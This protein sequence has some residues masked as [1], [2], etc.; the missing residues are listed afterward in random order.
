MKLHKNWLA[1]VGTVCGLAT[2]SVLAEAYVFGANE[3][4]TSNL[5]FGVGSTLSVADGA[6]VTALGPLSLGEN[7]A[8]DITKTDGGTFELAT[9]LPPDAAN[10]DGP[11][12]G[13]ASL[14]VSA[15]TFSFGA[16]ANFTSSFSGGVTVNGTGT[17]MVKGGTTRASAVA[18]NG[19]PVNVT[20]GSFLTRTLTGP[21]AISISGGEFGG[22][23]SFVAT[24]GAGDVTR[25]DVAEDGTLVLRNVSAPGGDMSI[26]VDGGTI[27]PAMND[28]VYAGRDWTG[29]TVYVGAKGLKIDLSDS[30]AWGPLWSLALRSEPG[31]T[32][33]GLFISAP[34][35]S[36]QFRLKTDDVSLSGGIRVQD[37][38]LDLLG[39][40][41]AS[42]PAHFRSSVTLEGNAALR[43]VAGS[44]TVDRLVFS[45]A[46]GY[47]IFGTHAAGASVVVPTLV[48]NDF[49]PPAGI[50]RLGRMKADTTSDLLMTAG[51]Y[52]LIKFPATVACGVSRFVFERNDSG[53]DYRLGERTE[54]GW[55]IIS[56][57]VASAGTLDF[58]LDP[59]VSDAWQTGTALWMIG[60]WLYVHSAGSLATAAPLTLT[61]A[62]NRVAGISVPDGDTL[63]LSGGLAERM[64]GFAKLGA[65]TLALTGNVG[66]QFGRAFTS[67]AG[68]SDK[69]QNLALFDGTANGAACVNTHGA[70]LTVGRGTLMIGT[71]T[72]APTVKIPV[73][74]LDVG[75]ATTDQP[76]VEGDAELVMNSGYL[77]VAG[78]F[79]VGVNHGLPATRDKDYL[80]SSYVQN[81][82]TSEV[83]YVNLCFD[84]SKIA[85]SDARFTLNGGTFACKSRF[86]AGSQT[87]ASPYP[88]YVRFTQTGGYLSVG[89]ENYLSEGEGRFIGKQGGNNDMVID[90]TMTGGEAM[91]WKGF[92]VYNGGTVTVNLNGGR[93]AFADRFNGGS[94]ATLN[95]NGTVVA[96]QPK[97]DGSGITY[98]VVWFKAVNVLEGNAIV[99]VSA[100]PEIDLNQALNGPGRLV[101]RG[102]NTNNV[103]RI[104]DAVHNLGGVTVEEGGAVLA[105]GKSGGSLDFLVKNGG[106]ICNYYNDPVKD[107][108]LGELES[109]VTVLYGYDVNGSLTSL[110]V[111][112]SLTVNGTVWVASRAP[113]GKQSRSLHPGT[114]V[115][116]R[117][118]K[119]TIDPAKFA[120]HP[121]LVA[122]GGAATFSVDTSN[123]AYDA[124]VATVTSSTVVHTWTAN[125]SGAWD[126]DA[127]WDLPPN[128]GDHEQIVFPASIP[129][130]VVVAADTSSRAKKVDQNAAHTVTVNGPFEFSTVD[131]NNLGVFDIALTN[132]VLELAGPVRMLGDRTLKMTRSSKGG[133]L[134]ISGAVEG[135]PTISKASGYIE[136]R[137]EAFGGATLDLA[138][139]ILRF[140]RSGTF[141]GTV[142][143]PTSNAT[144]LG[145]E[146]PP[147]ET[148]YVPGIFTN[149][150]AF[151]MLGGGRLVLGNEGMTFVGG[152]AK[153]GDARPVRDVTTGDAPN[154]QGLSVIAGTLELDGGDDAEYRLS[155]TGVRIGTQ[156]IPDG[157][158]GAY[159]ARLVIR[160]GAATCTGEF[161]IGR[162]S[163]ELFDSPLELGLTKR[164]YCAVDVYGGSLTISSSMLINYAPSGT[165]P[166]RYRGNSTT[167]RWDYFHCAK[168]ELNVHGG[169][170]IIG[171]AL[172]VPYHDTI[173]AVAEGYSEANVNI[174]GGLIDVLDGDVSVGRYA[175][176]YNQY[177]AR[178]TIN[179][180]S[181][182]IRTV[183]T[184][185]VMLCVSQN[186]IGKLNLRGGVLEAGYINR[187]STAAN[188][189]AH[190]LFDGGTFKSLASSYTFPNKTLTSLMVGEG[191]A[192]FD[193]GESNAVTL[194]QALNKAQD[195][196]ADGGIA[197]TATTADALLTLKVANAFNGPLKVDG[198]T[199]RPTVAAAASCAS[200]VEVNN[201][202]VFDANGFDFTFGFLR[203]D[204]GVYSNG[205]V[206]VT[207][208]VAPS[209]GT[210][211]VGNL[212]LAGG[213]TLKCP[214]AGDATAGW[215][216]PYLTVA[217][218]VAKAG[219]AFLDL[220]HDAGNPLAKGCRVKV[221]ELAEGVDAFPSLR[222]T[223]IG[224]P[225]AG[226][227]LS[228]QARED[229]VTEIWAEVVPPAFML[230][231]R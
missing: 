171:T 103:L 77:S 73:A 66:Y 201:G 91:F 115:F 24:A 161:D 230:I 5:V 79:N 225:G 195:V 191:G 196:A 27:R 102:S 57:T 204:G 13:V 207:G 36:C 42:T 228:R 140:T 176:G 110:Y 211:T 15:G 26:H 61:P 76:G 111:T 88:A 145:V 68:L 28:T 187:S 193:L 217:G 152:A 148:V 109:D 222:A 159:D 78:T 172:W 31:V 223:G 29:G 54:N 19:R 60:S 231:F 69:L 85:Q 185:G 56:L 142:W 116:L 63:T 40:D 62:Q 90:Y 35:N 97:A 160:S 198:G 149:S 117:A 133:T 139:S 18:L 218:S 130:D 74:T 212:V 14:T 146:V 50:I 132:G 52:D 37:A 182:T 92:S 123:A 127:N 163:K 72:D 205:T 154:A 220:G 134:R 120:L 165:G 113:T 100:I 2:G 189:Q 141:W 41:Y 7:A 82:G 131:V 112:N 203:G 1:V 23:N 96:P 157:T 104:Y 44:T 81:G 20:G 202:G 175:D 8:G 93:L 184:K 158:G 150:T 12:G 106:A 95:W 180:D 119:G 208:E 177:P 25:I 4:T 105:R 89:Y 30:Q 65:G 38:Q 186:S 67:T 167:A 121:D 47:V 197:L 229:G 178:G 21:S 122:R 9:V 135:A 101:V 94:G 174:D 164:P 33:G 227:S 11:N 71:G 64:G 129:A 126:D 70:A 84:S 144:G 124:L 210:F 43:V 168:S 55:R 48:V 6:T 206:T 162:P 173:T 136:G 128:G 108:T 10:G 155:T 83:R 169:E 114:T 194:N 219:D 183:A 199:M 45:Q 51:T 107:L 224:L 215:S 32:D 216:A 200:G 46:E 137:P 3:T 138:N 17:I 147:G 59:R 153:S 34:G 213:A 98:L 87:S 214:V 49:V 22:T 209:N 192:K 156:P 143:H 86:Y 166:K 58:G 188:T 226:V 170:V 75:T 181:G 80:V 190:V 151:S 53:Y 179:M 125:A 39:T 16:G 221:A 99:D 118:P